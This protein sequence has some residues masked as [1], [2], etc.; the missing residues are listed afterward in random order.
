MDPLDR[1]IDAMASSN[2]P[3]TLID[4]DDCR[5]PRFAKDY[6]W[7][8]Q[9]RVRAAM[10]AVLQAKFDAMW[11]RLQEH[12]DDQRYVL[13]ASRNG[14]AQNFS[15]GGFCRVF[16]SAD[17]SIAYT[18]HLPNVAGRLPATFHPEELFWKNEQDWIRMRKPLYEIQIEICQRAVEQW[19]AVKGTVTGEEG[20]GHTYTPDE[21]ARF[22]EAVTK[23]I[24]ELRRLRCAVFPD[25]ILPGIAA[26]SGWEG[27]DET[28]EL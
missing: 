23:E 14:R 9:R 6:D 11:R 15:V 7:S 8:E 26:P 24:E 4:Q 22:I 5:V 10:S 1:L 18:R 28:S 27:F 21:K 17:L 19:P 3:P 2:T 16:F 13:T 25:A 20:E 12:V